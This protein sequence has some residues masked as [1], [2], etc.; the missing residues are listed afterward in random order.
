M[1]LKNMNI[2]LK[3]TLVKAG[4]FVAVI[5]SITTGIYIAYRLSILL[6]PF[7]IAFILSSLIE[8]VVS[9]SEKRFG[10]KRKLSTPIVLLLIISVIGLLLVMIIS[11]L[12]TELKSLAYI[13]PDVLSALYARFTEFT[14]RVTGMYGWLPTEVTE[15]IGSIIVSFSNS[16][17]KLTDQIVKGAFATAISLPQI[18]VFISI[19]LMAAYF[20][21][22]DRY[23]IKK[24]I[25]HQLPDNWMKKLA[26]IKNKMF[27]V[28][29]GYIKAALILMAMTFIELFAGL[30]IIHIRYA[31]LLAFLIAFIDALPV[32]GIGSVLIPW[33]I[34]NYIGGDFRLG[35]S[36]LIL[37]VI[38]FI[39]RQITEPKIIGRQIG[40]HPLLTLIAMYTGLQLMGVAGLILGPVTFL[41]I[42]CILSGIY[43]KRT[44]KDIV[45]RN[46]KL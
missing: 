16:L 20:M 38:I 22:S 17:V 41:L 32:I 35:T 6:A 24:Y 8:P 40:V 4:V 39:I 18:L 11:R 3:S 9:F 23:M 2:R 29:T 5:A 14:N 34:C 46:F 7:L 30:S 37:Y 45:N 13:L 44:L 19:T 33:A 31:L 28:L 26:V 10:L 21:S 36:I 43:G 42:K 1:V 15:K 12:I 25:Q 27:S